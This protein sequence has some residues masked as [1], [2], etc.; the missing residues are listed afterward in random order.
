MLDANYNSKEV[1]LSLYKTWEENNYFE[2]DSNKDIAKEG[3]NFCLMMPP[4][5]ITGVLHI[6][7]ALTFTLQDLIV[8]YKRMDGYRTLW[9]AGTDH[10]GIATQNVVERKLLEQN[11]KKDEID[12]EEFLKKVW[13]WKDF[14]GGTIVKQMK[15]IGVSPSWSRDRFTLDDGLQNAV[16]EAFIKLYNDGFII[17]DKYM[18]NW[19]TKDGAISDIEVEHKEVGGKLYYIKYFLKDENKYLS[20]AT[21]RPE[22]LFGDTAIMV[23]PDDD[24]Y[25]D[26]I[27]KSIILP[28]SNREIEI[29]SDEY[30]D[31]DFATGVVK[32]TP[33]HDPNDYEVGKR[34]KLEFIGIFDEKGVLN[35]NCGEFKGIDRLI[36]R[37]KIVGKLEKE[38]FL[39]K[40]EEYRHKVGHCYRCKNIIEP[41]IS[42]QWFVKKEI[43]LASIKKTNDGLAKFFPSHWI[44]SY[45][46][47]MND[48]NDWCISRQLLWGHR[49]PVFYCRSCN[50]EWAGDNEKKCTK[51][52][53][54]DIFQDPDVLD[55]WFSS[56]LWPFSTLGWGNGGKNTDKYS[57][58]D[59]KNFYPNSLLITGFD[60]L[61]FW[62]SRMMIMG[63]YFNKKLPFNH[64]Y[65]HAL[66]R[67]ENGLKMSKDRGNIIDP[68]DIIEEFSADVMRF[69]L[70]ILAVQG[71]DI[72]LGK[73]NLEVYRNFS[74]KLY[75]GAKY[76]TMNL[77]S[78]S[79]LKDIKLKTPLGLYM[80]SRLNE[81]TI[82]VRDF[83]DLYRFND[84]ALVLYKFIWNEFC[85]WGIEL[86]K[87]DKDSISELGSIFKEA[88]K[89][90]HPIMPFI[91][92]Y[93]YHKLSN[94][95][96]YK[97]KS[98]MLM[99]YPKVAKVDYN[100]QNIFESLKDSIVSIR[101]LKINIELKDRISK[102]YIKTKEDLDLRDFKHYIIKLAKVDEVEFVKEAK[103]GYLSDI[104]ERV[105]V[106][107][108]KEG[109]S[110]YAIIKRLENKK[111]KLEN[112]LLK[113]K[114]ILNNERFILNA[115]EEVKEKN[116]KD[117]KNF[118]E[119]LEDI[120]RSLSSLKSF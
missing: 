84:I 73:K 72:K 80:Y 17:R 7:H 36:A 112:E 70:V 107:M 21:S 40:I 76:L 52:N 32:V 97:D 23:N 114:N 31:K 104:G 103:D 118:K 100:I 67:D 86:S 61:F 8:R 116:K 119:K 12:R 15:R 102:I 68:L 27:G 62:V 9:Q 78:F 110:L 82:Q 10:A 59:L 33:A 95:D 42:K 113:L 38:G 109:I 94:T 93:L 19:C 30:V 64:I 66:V 3:K 74:N 29:I 26:F 37:A 83:F 117:Y 89:L 25:K 11:I 101:R 90:L 48:L 60:I 39:E 88:L 1:E 51:C 91:T 120:N 16:R 50:N 111:I 108:S 2:V 6:G 49:I 56:A 65:L 34:H 55:T 71:R 99:S 18:V 22:T 87:A 41:F 28:L 79:D 14:S 105:E 69:A 43:A 85:D 98:I 5:N 77:N 24:R 75:N 57:L 54:E 46:A 13:E 96:M 115:K 106:Y 35:E 20:I 4:P 92:E 63:E 53:S 58:D 44:N 81:A 47:W 45:N